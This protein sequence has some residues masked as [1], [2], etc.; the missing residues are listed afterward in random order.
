MELRFYR[1]NAGR[2]PVQ[3]Y[4]EA[5]EEVEKAAVLAAF[6]DLAQRGVSQ[7][8]VDLR[9]I[10]GKLWEI[11]VSR[12]RVFYV[13]I[14]GPMMLLLHAYKKQGQKAPTRELAVARGRMKEV[15]HGNG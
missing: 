6:E 2:A 12:H 15:L 8:G 11:R 7:T 9:H 10:Q 14:S 1:T 3:D 4:V 13:L 5:L